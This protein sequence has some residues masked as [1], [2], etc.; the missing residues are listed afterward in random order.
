MFYL[1]LW[2]MWKPVGSCTVLSEMTFFYLFVCC[3]FRTCRCPNRSRQE[4]RNIWSKPDTSKKAKIL[5]TAC[6]GGP[7]RCYPHHPGACCPNLTGT[8][9]LPA[10]WRKQWS[11]WVQHTTSDATTAT[12]VHTPFL[13]GWT[14]LTLFLTCP[15]RSSDSWSAEP[16]F[17]C[18]Y[19][20]ILAHYD[21]INCV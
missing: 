5:Y 9:L 10:S 11:M 21:C 2:F 17:V 6:L 4:K 12:V 20:C 16:I 8:F 1:W 18:E 15:K 3:F 7:T 14:G 19:M 13:I